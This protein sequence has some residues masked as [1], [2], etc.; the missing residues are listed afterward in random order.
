MARKG[1]EQGIPLERSTRP[2]RKVW[3]QGPR[4]LHE[5]R[6]GYLVVGQDRCCKHEE[7]SFVAYQWNNRWFDAYRGL[8]A[9]E[10]V[11]L[12]QGDEAYQS[13]LAYG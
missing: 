5:Q 4:R 13:T 9:F 8:Y 7:L 10:R 2:D 12:A 6:P 3:L 1:T 11:W